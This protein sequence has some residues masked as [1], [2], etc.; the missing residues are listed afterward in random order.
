MTATGGTSDSAV[1]G[2]ASDGG[3]AARWRSLCD[4]SRDIKLGA[5]RHMLTSTW[6]ALDSA[7]ADSPGLLDAWE[8]LDRQI[9]KFDQLEAEHAT[10]GFHSHPIGPENDEYDEWDAE[11]DEFVCPLGRC[12]RMS[13]PAR[14]WTAQGGAAPDRAP[15]CLLFG[16]E[17]MPRQRGPER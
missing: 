7:D 2:G 14:G 1:R 9:S 8:R 15:R 13:S 12:D 16:R 17:M 4:R 10:R 5:F 11:G 6:Q 3:A